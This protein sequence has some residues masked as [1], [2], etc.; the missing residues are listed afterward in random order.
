RGMARRLAIGLTSYLHDPRVRGVVA[1]VRD[2]SEQSALRGEA[3]RLKRRLRVF[4]ELAAD[5]TM[6]LDSNGKITFQSPSIQA[7]LGLAPEASLGRHVLELVV[8]QD[9]A[10]LAEAIRAALSGEDVGRPRNCLVH[11]ISG[12]GEERALWGVADALRGGTVS[13]WRLSRD[14]DAMSC[15]LLYSHMDHRFVPAW[16]SVPFPDIS[17]GPML[18]R[19][20]QM[21]PVAVS[22]TAESELTCE[23]IKD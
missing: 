3:V 6:L 5:L 2:V 10:R 17:F 13:Y 21:R 20:Q 18:A 8:E 11:A 14:A 22:D 9:R 19:L 23:L 7:S 1:R 4:A 16:S 15:E 12:S